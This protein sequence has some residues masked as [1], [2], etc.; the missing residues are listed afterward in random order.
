MI[1][2]LYRKQQLHCSI[3]KAWDFFTSPENLPLIA[4][5][6]MDFTVLTQIKY[7]IHEGMQVDYRLKPLFGIPIRWKSEVRKVDHKKSFVDYQL[8]GPYKMWHHYHEFIENDKGVLMK[9]ILNYE[10]YY[11]FIGKI[12]N[13]LIV[14]KKLEYIFSNRY[15]I[16][17][18]I[19]NQKLNVQQDLGEC[20]R[21][22]PLYNKSDDRLLIKSFIETTIS[23]VHNKI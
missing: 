17:N 5:Q 15:D 8:K 20:S 7:P 1:Y 6:E 12:I 9:D 18:Q 14:R 2:Q 22:N 21:E 13:R 23:N 16:V 3:D 11:S 19:F 4:P 10:M